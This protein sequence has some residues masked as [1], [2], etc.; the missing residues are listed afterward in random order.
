M[1]PSYGTHTIT[2]I[3]QE[4]S[5]KSHKINDRETGVGSRAGVGGI[6]K[7]EMVLLNCEKI[8]KHV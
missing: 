8:N 5:G 3:L 7:R 2:Y 6:Q 1:S 4:F